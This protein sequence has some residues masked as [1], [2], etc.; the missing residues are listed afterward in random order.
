MKNKIF[1]LFGALF[2]TGCALNLVTGRNQLSLVPEAELQLMATGQY[3]TFVSEHKVLS[4]GNKD[5]A[6]VD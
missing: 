4:P 1:F 3:K 6:M 5:A 2:L